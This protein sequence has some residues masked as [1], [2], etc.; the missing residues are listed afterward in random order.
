MATSNSTD[1]AFKLAFDMACDIKVLAQS[2][3]ALFDQEDDG[4]MPDI[5]RML[6]IIAERAEALAGIVGLQTTKGGAA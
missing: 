6:A 5:N 1:D 4:E 2:A 3:K